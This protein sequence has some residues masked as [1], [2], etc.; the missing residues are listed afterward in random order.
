M[1][2]KG[3]G[4]MQRLG[5]QKSKTRTERKDQ[6]GD[7]QAGRQIKKTEKGPDTRPTSRTGVVPGKVIRTGVGLS[8]MSGRQQFGSETQVRHFILEG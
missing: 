8:I 3:K 1:Q 6:D 7:R 5:Q 4:N 2:D